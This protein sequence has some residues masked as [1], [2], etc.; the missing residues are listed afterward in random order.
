MCHSRARRSVFFPRARFL[1][2]CLVLLCGRTRAALRAVFPFDGQDIIF[3]CGCRGGRHT[4][5]P[6]ATVRGRRTFLPFRLRR[7]VY[8]RFPGVNLFFFCAGPGSPFRSDHQCGVLIALNLKRKRKAAV[9]RKLICLVGY[10]ADCYIAK[11]V[12]CCSGRGN[13]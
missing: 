10:V 4:V 13:A 9:L 6:T 2:I 8:N 12:R 5:L 3:A 1:R 7:A 11:T